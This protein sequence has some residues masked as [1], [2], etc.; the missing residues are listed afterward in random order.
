MW[1]PGRLLACVFVGLFVVPSLVAG[2][3]ASAALTDEPTHAE[4]TATGLMRPYTTLMTKAGPFDPA[5]DDVPF[6]R[7]LRSGSD[8]ASAPAASDGQVRF[9]LQF[10]GGINP[11]VIFGLKGKGISLS[12]T[13]RRAA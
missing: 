3:P 13:Y 6:P 12:A 8:A 11:D 2:F 4:P 5:R 1:L 10:E 7:S 9:I